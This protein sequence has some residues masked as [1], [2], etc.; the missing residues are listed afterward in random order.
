MKTVKRSGPRI[1]PWG[2]PDAKLRNL[3]FR[4]LPDKTDSRKLPK[5]RDKPAYFSFLSRVP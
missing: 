1:E 5:E 3:T 2:I 4:F